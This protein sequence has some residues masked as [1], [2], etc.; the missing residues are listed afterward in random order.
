MKG[1]IKITELDYARISSLIN[2]FNDR[3]SRD[4][5]NVEVLGSEIQRAEKVDSRQIAPDFV[6]MNSL[7]EVTDLDTNRQI[8]LKL[9]YPKDADFRK[10]FISILSPLG[11]ALLGYKSGDT[12]SFEVPAGTK[13]VRINKVLYQPEAN[14]EFTV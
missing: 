10:G 2:A 13:K 1:E 4:L 14:G 12:I 3:K 7:I 6:T 11:C 5:K 9:V 8:T